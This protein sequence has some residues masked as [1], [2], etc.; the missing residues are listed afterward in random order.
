MLVIPL[1]KYYKFYTP[2]QNILQFDNQL[3][4]YNL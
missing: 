3:V 4:K 2:L 1:I